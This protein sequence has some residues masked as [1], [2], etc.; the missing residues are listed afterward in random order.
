MLSNVKLSKSFWVEVAW[1]TCFLINWSPSFSIDKKTP[2][3][4]WSSTPAVYFDLK[5]FG[6]PTYARVDNRKLEPRSIK[7]LFLGYKNGVKGYK[8]W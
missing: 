1:T 8:L 4:I 5:I 6:C 3:E 7:C 2:I